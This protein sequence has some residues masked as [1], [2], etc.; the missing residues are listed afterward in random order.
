MGT[1]MAISIVNGFFCASPCDVSKA[2]RGEEPHPTTD[3]ANKGRSGQSQPNGSWADQPAV[4]FGGSLS[5]LSA[6]DRVDPAANVDA[7]AASTWS[8]QRPSV[9][10][11]A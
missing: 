9:D 4:L 2:K 6:L 7:S 5:G 10:V 11:L 1:P 3:T 8:G